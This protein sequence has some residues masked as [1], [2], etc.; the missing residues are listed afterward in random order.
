[1]GHVPTQAVVFLEAPPLPPL[2]DAGV[3]RVGQDQTHV[4]LAPAVTPPGGLSPSVEAFSNGLIGLPVGAGFQIESEYLTDIL[5]LVFHHLRLTVRPHDVT[6][7][8]EIIF[9]LKARPR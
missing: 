6:V 4:L 5:G 1:M 3:R 7:W 8:G 2:T 9:P